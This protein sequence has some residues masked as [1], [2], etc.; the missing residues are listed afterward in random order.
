MRVVALCDV[1]AMFA[2]CAVA[3]DASLRGRPVIV[4][5]DPSDR[6]SIVLTASYEARAYGV[7]TAMPLRGALRLCPSAVLVAPDHD[8]YRRYSRRLFEVLQEFTPVVAPVSIDEA[9]L[10]LTGCPGLREGP[11]ALALRIRARVLE[12]TQLTVSLGVADGRWPAKMAANLAKR[13]PAG[14]V[15]LGPKD[16]EQRIWPLPVRTFHGVGPKTAERLEGLSIH[17]IGDL[18]QADDAR[19]RALG[20]QGKAMRL[21]ARGIDPSPVTDNAPVKS[22]SHELTFANDIARPDDLRPVLLGL[23]DQVAYRLSRGGHAAQT[24]TLRVRNRDFLDFSRQLTLP[25]PRHRTDALHGAV[26]RL[27]GRMPKEAFPARLVGVAAG[28]IS[29]LR[30]STRSLFPDE[31]EMRRERLA[32]TVHM[33]KEKFGED[34]VLPLGTVKSPVRQS[35]D[36]RRHGSSFGRHNAPKDKS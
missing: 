36:R 5:G 28:A 27:L 25:E 22:I 8:L 14:V 21:L 35:Y 29:D 30:Q 24:V 20:G 16:L 4:S 19:L 2:S 34:A 15:C 7:Q 9:Y 12:E 26:L 23:C 1:N 31:A 13:D 33:L 32:D 11:R 10:D 18:A 6:R 17:T 3:E